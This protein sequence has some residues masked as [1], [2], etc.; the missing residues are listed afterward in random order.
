MMGYY[1]LSSF[2]DVVKAYNEIVPIRGARANEDLR[3]LAER[4]YWWMRVVKVTDNKYALCDGHWAW[5]N[6]INNDNHVREQTAP[7]L[8]ERKDD[9]DYISIRNHMNGGMSVSRYTFLQNFLPRSMYF[10]Y[11]Q[12][13]GKHFVNHGGAEHYLPK[14]KGNMDWQ[15]KT[16]EM[17]QDNKLV[18]KANGDGNFTRVNNLQP[19]QKFIKLIWKTGIFSQVIEVRF[20]TLSKRIF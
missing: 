9:G 8:W 18:F 3:P 10:H 13:E 16:F 20:M 12:G 6:H 11:P 4:R 2:D 19:M 1:K 17:I 15:A 7:I 5:S 14:F